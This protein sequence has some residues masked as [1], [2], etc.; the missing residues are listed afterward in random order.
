MR[1]IEADALRIRTPEGVTFSLPLAG[2]VRRCLAM[3]LDTFCISVIMTTVGYAVRALSIVGDDVASAV[4]YLFYFVVS[5]G[6]S[7]ALEWRWRGQTVGKR[8]LRLRVMDAEGLRLRPAQVILRNLLRPVDT[9]PL[10]YLLGGAITFFNGR[11][12]RLGDLAA[13]TVVV[14]EAEIEEPDF[15]RIAPTKF[16]S[17]SAYPHLAARLR[18]RVPRSLIAVTFEALLRRDQFDPAARL[19]LYKEL[20]ARFQAEADFPP[21]ATEDL[22]DEQYLRNVLEVIAR[23]L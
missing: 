7:I 2:P 11:R 20:A 10:L 9:L 4:Y 21:A 23:K 5:T 22:S 16:N 19:E 17:L 6:Y 18:M 14:V 13:G 1:A 3:V 12:Q 15:T 8:V